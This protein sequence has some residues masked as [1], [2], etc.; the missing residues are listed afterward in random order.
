MFSPQNQGQEPINV[1]HWR[2]SKSKIKLKIDDSM[3]EHKTRFLFLLLK[4]FFLGEFFSC[5]SR[6]HH[7]NEQV[8]VLFGWRSLLLYN[9]FIVKKYLTNFY[10]ILF[11]APLLQN[12]QECSK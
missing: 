5:L 4:F 10:E 9:Q 2:V 3:G 11:D 8:D 7:L 1:E 12:R 6:R